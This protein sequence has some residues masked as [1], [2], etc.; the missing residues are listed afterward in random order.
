MRL[1]RLFSNRELY[2]SYTKVNIKKILS[3]KLEKNDFTK[4]GLCDQ[5]DNCN[6]YWI[7]TTYV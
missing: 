4:S 7:N 5:R 3:Q 6:H 2:S 1:E